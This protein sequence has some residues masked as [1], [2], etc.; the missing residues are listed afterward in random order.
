VD[1]FPAANWNLST[2]NR[3][4]Q[5]RWQQQNYTELEFH[6]LLFLPNFE[7]RIPEIPVT[8]SATILGVMNEVPL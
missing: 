6:G 5:K 7:D 3:G 2:N 8:A 1:Y 4:K